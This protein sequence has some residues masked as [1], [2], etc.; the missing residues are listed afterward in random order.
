M[1]SLIAA[2]QNG[3][4]AVYLGGKLFNARKNASNFDEKEMMEAVSYAHLRGVKVYVTVNILLDDDEMEKAIDY[5]R[6]LYNIDVDALI[7]QDLGFA[8]LVRRIFPSMELHASTQ[9]TINNLYGA[10]YLKD[11]G[12]TRVVLARETSLEDIKAI[13]DKVNIEVESFV[14]GALCM[15]YS[16]QCLMSSLI[17]GRS[18]NRG[19]C[20]Q[21]CRMMYSIIDKQ[22][23]LLKDWDKLHMLSPKDLNT[24][25]NTERLIEAGITSFKI[26]GRMK[27]PEY[28]AT[29]T[30]AY[31][32]AIDQGVRSISKGDKDDVL[33]IFNRDFTKG[34]GF[35]DFGKTFV[36]S[37]RPDNRGTVLGQIVNVQKHNMQVLLEK[38]LREQDGLEIQLANG[39]YLGLNS[40]INAKKGEVV[41]LSKPG[42]VNIGDRVN[43]SSSAELLQRAKD[44]YTD[45][46]KTIPIKMEVK[47]DKD[48][49]PELIISANNIKFHIISDTKAEASKNIALTEERVKEQLSK[50]GDTIYSLKEMDIS[51]DD[52]VFF[53]IKGLNQLRREAVDKLN[54]QI[55]NFNK[56]E[57]IKDEEF[58]KSKDGLFQKKYKNYQSNEKKLS[59][60]IRNIEQLNRLDREKVDRIYLNFTNNL[61]VAIKKIKSYDIEVY[62]STKKILENK[63]FYEL[64]EL[65][66]N[67][68]GLDGVSISNLG[69]L[70]FVKERFKG[71]KI[72][73]DI[74]LN[75]FNSYTID[76]F[77][78]EGMESMTLSAELNFK[79]IY[80]LSRES[81]IKVEGIS[82]GYLPLMFIKNCPMAIVKKCIDDKNCSACIYNHGF[83][84]EDRMKAQFLLDRKDGYTILYN[85]VPLFVLDHNTLKSKMD[86]IRLDFTEEANEVA[87]I[88]TLYYDFINGK[89]GLDHVKAFVDDYKRENQ[90]TNGHYYRGVI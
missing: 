75:I 66:N 6:F 21:P 25:E 84:L 28:V 58:G 41:S 30:S 65:L 77:K 82:Y 37:D 55:G 40:K 81:S 12:F 64:E 60:S 48:K 69:T 43:K 22:G 72:H 56:R 76:H 68:E 63:D 54:H 61:E 67:V 14:H 53:T 29:I 7:V 20:A 34:L 39:K 87:N 33:Q 8:A 31:R 50:L 90:I 47:I 83:K 35:G 3:A 89:I 71:L 26:E 44:S 24:L 9:M 88:Q 16:G 4:N 42:F 78:D 52:D 38:D 15:S 17:G 80:K 70:Q 49:Y 11:L 32:K 10:E 73:G 5:V 79:Q 23:K 18:G 57:I 45:V 1:E 36:S 2:V 46:D 19:T 74:G 51:L 59:I 85:S 13:C 62:Y 27:R 86:F